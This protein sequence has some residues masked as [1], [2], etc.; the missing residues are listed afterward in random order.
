MGFNLLQISNLS[1]HV[2]SI[3]VDGKKKWYIDFDAHINVELD[4]I[5]TELWKFFYLAPDYK[6]KKL[7][8]GRNY[9]FHTS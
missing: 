5:G 7:N 3:I 2:K 6:E 8:E 9:Y 1:K 4:D